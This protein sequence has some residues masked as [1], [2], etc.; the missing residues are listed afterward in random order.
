MPK[1]LLLIATPV[2]LCFT[3]AIAAAAPVQP[4]TTA[5]VLALDNAWSEAE[6]RGDAAFVEGLLLPGYRM[7]T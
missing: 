2:M 1:Q 7:E 5:T 3:S 6:I 4:K